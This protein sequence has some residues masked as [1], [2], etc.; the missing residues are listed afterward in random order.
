LKSS[1]LKLHQALIRYSKGIIAA[2]E[3]WIKEQKEID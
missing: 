1:T 3:I 2:W